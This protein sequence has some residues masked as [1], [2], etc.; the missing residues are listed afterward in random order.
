MRLIHAAEDKT[1]PS[2]KCMHGMPTL[3]SCTRLQSGWARTQAGASCSVGTQF[4]VCMLATPGQHKGGSGRTNA[5]HY[6][7]TGLTPDGQQQMHAH[8]VATGTVSGQR[9]SRAH[10]PPDH[11]MNP[12]S[13]R[14]EANALQCSPPNPS[15]VVS[16]RCRHT[17]ST[18]GSRERL[19]DEQHGGLFRQRHIYTR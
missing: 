8:A 15:K 3:C 2:L 11:W 7:L 1:L 16:H 10:L 13:W 9:S 4:E 12:L 14:A 17:N 18:C 6:G 19:T 5:V